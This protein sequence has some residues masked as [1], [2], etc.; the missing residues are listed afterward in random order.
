M[1]RIV[2]MSVLPGEPTDG[3]GR[4]CIHLFI[5]DEKG[6]F[7]EPHVLHEKRDEQGEV[8]KGELVAKPARGRLAC[9]PRKQVASV[10][11]GN[12]IHITLRSDSPGAVSCPKC[13]MSKYY[14]DMMAKRGGK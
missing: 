11:K 9:D 14:R 8:I 13:K 4:V 6:P 12:A 7:V 5:K 1:K 3:S 2:H 10:I